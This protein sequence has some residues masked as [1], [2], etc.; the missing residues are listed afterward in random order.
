VGKG[1]IVHGSEFTSF[2]DFLQL[3]IDTIYCPH[4]FHRLVESKNSTLRGSNPVGRA[5][6]RQLTNFVPQRRQQ[7]S[8]RR[9]K[10][11][12]VINFMTSL[13]PRAERFADYVLVS[14][15]VDVLKFGALPDEV[16]DHAPLSLEFAFS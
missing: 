11:F 13:Y 4:Q 8:P 9:Y 16:S 7:I 15:G 12:S 5:N 1:G 3:I 2:S 14:P 6:Y 10:P